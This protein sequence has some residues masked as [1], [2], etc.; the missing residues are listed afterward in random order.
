MIPGRAFPPLRLPLPPV[1]LALIGLIVRYR[2]WLVPGAL[3]VVNLTVGRDIALNRVHVFHNFDRVRLP[4]AVN[5]REV[6]MASRQRDG[7]ARGP[8]INIRRIH[9]RLI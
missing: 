6:Q 1:A 5:R 2:G 4:V 8:V 7:S 9:S 3:V